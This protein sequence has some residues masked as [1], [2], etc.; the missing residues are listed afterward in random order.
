M[1]PTSA[2]AAFACLLF[3]A[4]AAIAQDDMADVQIV[5]TDLGNGLFMLSGAGGNLALS[6]GED[7]T[8]LVD[9]ELQPLTEKVIAAVAAQTDVPVSFVVNTHWHF[10]HAGGNE[11]LGSDG[12]VIIAHDNV[13]TRMSNPHYFE[14]FDMH[15][16]ASAHAALPV[17][18]FADGLTLHLNGEDVAV[19]HVAPAHTDG[20]A[21]VVFEGA[22]VV[23]LGDLFFN[24]FYP[25]I[26]LS[27]D[28]S[29]AGMIDAANLAL[30][31]VDDDTRIIPGH[32]PLGSKADLEAFRD[33]LVAVAAAVQARID[34]G[35]TL[36]QA[37]AAAPTAAYDAEWADGLLTPDQFAG[38]VYTDLA[39]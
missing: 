39:D 10:D 11:R 13:R 18:T 31:M 8:F 1:K 32:G 38:I 17:I 25:F 34:E 26:D 29:V 20:D 35:M 15:V 33:M 5:T 14:A 28:G 12:A 37:V 19:T 3:G 23:H 4:T 22:N 16:P 7:G 24:G 27:S 6:V 9:D 30:T 21:I 36:E 2:T